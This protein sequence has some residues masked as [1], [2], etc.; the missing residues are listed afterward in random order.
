MDKNLH[1]LKSH[2]H[3]VGIGGI[4]MCGLAHLLVQMGATVSGS[5]QKES[6]QTYTLEQMGVT[7]SIGHREGLVEGKDVVVVSTA[8]PANNPEIIEA[9]KLGIPVIAR[10]EALAEMMRLK[11]GIAVAGSHGKTT[12]TSLL[13]MSFLENNQD[14]TVFVGGVVQSLG[15]TA[16]YGSGD[17]LI[18]EADESDGSFHKLAPE[19]V[20]LTNVDYDHLD[21]YKSKD[22]QERSFYRFAERIPF[23]GSLIYCGDDG[24]LN[25]LLTEFP[26]K[27]Y[28]YGFGIEND[29]QLITLQPSK[30][31]L[32]KLPNEKEIEL[33][34]SLPG[35]H[36]ALNALSVIATSD[37]LGLNLE[38]VKHS[39]ESFRGVR[40]RFQVLSNY[41]GTFIDDYAHHP[42]E[43]KNVLKTAKESFPGQVVRVFFQP[44]RY[45][46]LQDF[47][48]EFQECFDGADEVFLLDVY[49]A[50][51][52]PIENVNSEV[53]A[54]SIHQ[55]K[56]IGGSLYDL[57]MMM[58]SFDFS[59]SVNLFLGAGDIYKL[60]LNLVERLE[61][62]LLEA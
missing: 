59:N 60:S 16:T 52:A 2:I 24:V 27:K 35:D 51:E 19:I 53:L 7:V 56:H 49:S 23:Y 41:K 45:T 54:Q 43:I 62:T 12:T 58:E 20:I 40:R 8:I 1:L 5:D 10:A 18:A 36:N 44:H 15:G 31:Y 47:W 39:I 6:D 29:Y 46:R 9:K 48:T 28:S 22:K 33:N 14:P 17:W 4:G 38:K 25:R 42:T 13:G 57:A 55:A 37:I 61:Q 11:R 34:L 32:C 50:G 21:F 30:K 26:K 3:F